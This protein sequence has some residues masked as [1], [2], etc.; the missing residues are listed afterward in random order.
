MEDNGQMLTKYSRMKRDYGERD[1]DSEDYECRDSDSE[2]SETRKHRSNIY[3]R[4]VI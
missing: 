2:T 4:K 1:S 3:S